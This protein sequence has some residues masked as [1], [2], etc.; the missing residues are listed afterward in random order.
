ML[1][2]LAVPTLVDGLC[3]KPVVK[4]ACS[5]FH[6]VVMTEEN[7]IYAFGRNDFGQCGF[8]DGLDT[9]LPQRIP[10]FSSKKVLAIA[11]GQYHTLVSLAS[12]GVYAF[13]KNDHGQLG[14]A[15]PGAKSTPVL[16]SAPLHTE[17][18]GVVVQVACGYYHS[19][20][21][22][23]SGKVYTFG[24]NDF[25]QLGLGHK[26]NMF[27]PTVKIY[28]HLYRYGSTATSLCAYGCI[29]VVSIMSSRY[30][31]L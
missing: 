15:S 1:T 21:L 3:G 7:E 11:C 23:Q 5:Y 14:V 2:P 30:S 16:V 29:F 6:T 31:A 12:G 25:G 27:C 13:G 9:H 10:F 26:H 24:R 20:A 18:I 22:T 19:I 17:D 4:V 8:L 28:Q